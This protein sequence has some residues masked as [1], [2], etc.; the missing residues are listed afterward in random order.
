MELKPNAVDLDVILE[1]I[2]IKKPENRIKLNYN[3]I[4]E[5]CK[6]DTEVRA[7]IAIESFIFNKYFYIHSDGNKLL[8]AKKTVL[9]F[10]I[11]LSD[12]DIFIGKLRSNVFG[13]KYNFEFSN[14]LINCNTNY[15]FEVVYESYF[16]EKGRPR[17]F[18]VKLNSLKLLN[19]KP[20]YNSQT[21]TYNLNFSGRVTM[22]SI[23]NFQVIHPLEPAYI[24]LTFGK[25]A[26][27]LYMV[28]FSHPWS[29]LFAFCLGLSSL[30]HKFGCD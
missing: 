8:Y 15:K 19:K 13:T 9:G 10:N 21:N 23:R 3:K 2:K 27:N 28:D 6:I 16:F 5:K 22:P 17:I 26:E 1:N 7:K 25:E 18:E 29:I 12:S 20:F 30:D 14:N 4:V 24:T 11:Y